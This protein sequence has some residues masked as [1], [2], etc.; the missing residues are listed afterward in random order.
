M[1]SS[2]ANRPAEENPMNEADDDIVEVYSAADITEAAFLRDLLEE[3]GIR[4]RVVGDSL[5][6]AV[7]LLP[8]GEETA[9]RL[10]VFRADEGKAREMLA[11]YERVHRRPHPDDDPP[12]ESWQCPTCGETVETDF[13]LC[14]NCQTPRK[15]Y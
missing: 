3:A 1:R 2:I 7:G 10:W 9:P 12:A 8:P 6:T 5:Q 14:W 11:D 13:E 4:T 15:P